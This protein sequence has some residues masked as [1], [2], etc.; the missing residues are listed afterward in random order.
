MA[1]L[2]LVSSPFLSLFLLEY[3]LPTTVSPG[4]YEVHVLPLTMNAYVPSFSLALDGKVGFSV[5]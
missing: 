3:N 1:L 4:Q 2:G 5:N